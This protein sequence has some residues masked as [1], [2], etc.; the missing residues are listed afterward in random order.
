MQIVFRPTKCTSYV[1]KYDKRETPVSQC[2][3]G[4]K[5]VERLFL[6]LTDDTQTVA[7][8]L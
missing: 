7:S 3:A 1:Y 8:F 6:A 4:V 5:F 2:P